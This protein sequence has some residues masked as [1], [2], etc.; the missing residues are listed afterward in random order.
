VVEGQGRKID[1]TM[2]VLS[3]EILLKMPLNNQ[4]INMLYPYS[5][6]H[7]QVRLVNHRQVRLVN[8][9][10]ARLVNH[11]QVKQWLRVECTLFVIY[12]PWCEPTPIGDRLD[13][14]Y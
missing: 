8:H 13:T 14:V 9:R 1:I 5:T 3:A 12:K 6:I 4:S 7:R 10:Q 11:R 2:S